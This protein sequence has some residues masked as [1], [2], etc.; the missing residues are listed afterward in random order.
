MEVQNKMYKLQVD[1]YLVKV[2]VNDGKGGMVKQER[3]YIVKDVIADLA[4]SPAA[5]LNGH[6]LLKVN[7]TVDKILACTEKFIDLEDEEFAP[8]KKAIMEFEGVTRQEVELCRRFEEAEH[9]DATKA[10]EDAAKKKAKEGS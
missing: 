7:K 9:Y 3:P 10:K 5:K 2:V 6:R 8:I 4:L 1:D